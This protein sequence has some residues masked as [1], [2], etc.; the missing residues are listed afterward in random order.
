M[1]KKKINLKLLKQYERTLEKD[2]QYP[3]IRICSDESGEV[4]DGCGELLFYFDS[5]VELET[6][7]AQGE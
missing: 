5:I 2:Q 7:L 4:V 1:A 3:E 6:R